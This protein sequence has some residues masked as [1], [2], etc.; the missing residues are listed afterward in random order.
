[1]DGKWLYYAKDGESPS[2]IWK[3]PTSG[4]EE[5]KVVDHLSYSL[6]FVVA[7]R[8]IYF[9]ALQGPGSLSL[10][11]FEFATRKTAT[12]LK[13]DKPWWYG[14]AVSPNQRELLF[15]TVDQA[16]SDLMLVETFR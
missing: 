6:N 12:I 11:F 3:T 2:S 4:G 1:M 8:G 9:L 7:N 15:S 13:L 16:G 5:T 14:M 10:D